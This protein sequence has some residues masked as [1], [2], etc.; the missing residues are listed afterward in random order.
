MNIIMINKNVFFELLHAFEYEKL[1][2]INN[3]DLV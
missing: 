1:S 2:K 3:I